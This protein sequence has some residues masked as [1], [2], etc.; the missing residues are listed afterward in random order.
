LI[1]NIWTDGACSGNPG[2]GGFAAVLLAFDNQGV[3]C[4]RKILQGSDGHTT[5]NIMEMSAVI[6]GLGALKKSCNVTV[7][8]D[9][10][11]VCNG[12]MNWMYSWEQRGWKKADGGQVK[13]LE[14]WQ[15]LFELAKTH[16]ITMQHVK[17]HSGIEMN[18]YVDYLAVQAK[19]GDF[20]ASEPKLTPEDEVL[21]D[22]EYLIPEEED[23][24][25][26]D[27]GLDEYDD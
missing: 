18:E 25:D 26:L 15:E 6:A 10:Q 22:S 21:E 24:E 14:L 9:S 20:S 11:Y 1:I 5:N 17:A 4:S 27:G 7:F 13:N 23:I 8:S 19:E 2:K 16:N 3:E 12:V